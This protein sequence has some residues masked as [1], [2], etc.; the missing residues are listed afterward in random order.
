LVDEALAKAGVSDQANQSRPLRIITG[1]PVLDP[2]AL[3]GLAG[4]IVKVLEPHTEADPAGLLVS[5]LVEFG[6]QVG[7][8]PH[9]V[10]D[11]APHPARLFAALVGETAKGR[12]G[13]IEANVRRITGS[14]DRNFTR[15]RRLNGFGSGEALVDAVRGDAEN[16]DRRL[17]VVEPEFARI[18]NV[19][20]RDGSTLSQIIRQAWDGGRLAVRSRA[21]TTVVDDSHV[22]VVAHVSSDELRSKLTETEVAAGFANRFLFVCVRR[23]KLLPSGG[24]LDDGEIAPFVRKFALF[25][26]EARKIGTLRR[27]AEAEDLWTQLYHEMAADEPGGLLAAVIARDSAQ[28]LRLSVTYALTDGTNKIEV[29]HVRA[30]WALWRY[31]RASAAYVFGESL[32]DPVADRLLAA[33]QDAGHS[34]L[35]GRQRNTL[36]AGHV[37]R[38]QLDAAL[39]LLI[40]KDLVFTE[41]IETGG[42]PI[43]VV[44]A[45]ECEQSEQRALVGQTPKSPTKPAPDTH[46]EQSGLS[47]QRSAD[48]TAELL[49]AELLAAEHLAREH[50]AG[51]TTSMAATLAS[52]AAP[53]PE[54]ELPSRPPARPLSR[55]RK[56]SRRR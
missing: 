26:S 38:R 45:R 1:W 55:P 7:A 3:Y 52:M 11:S 34:G 33:I 8:G 14:A 17:L 6:A 37:S 19:A 32:G 29:E 48:E 22:C 9:A 42:R 13:T 43:E 51:T 50:I 31:C 20:R 21:G 30:A 25:A 53:T 54:P 15:D 27:T 24:N 28:V 47:E 12:K 2:D 16:T 10:A 39:A 5:T 23:S 35:D 56:R 4:E 41:A 49:A 46:C 18:L 40:S 36:F 44:R